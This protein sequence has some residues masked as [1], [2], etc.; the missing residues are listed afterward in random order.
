ME[1]EVR[2]VDA[3][4]FESQAD[5]FQRII[6]GTDAGYFR[7][8]LDGRFE[9]VN[10]AWLRMY[11]F[12]SREEV[13][14]LDF[15]AVQVPADREKAQSV[16]EAL[17]RGESV[18]AGEFSRLRRDGTVGYHN[19]SASPVVTGGRIVGIEGFLVDTSAIRAAEQQRRETEQQYRSLFNSMHEGVAVHKILTR[20]GIPWNY[21]VLDVNHR[22]EE[23]LGI[24]R[25]AVVGKLATDAYGTTEPPYLSEY[26]STVQTKRPCHFDTYFAPMDRYFIISVAPMGGDLFATI[27]FDITEQ[28]R[29]ELTLRQSQEQFQSI[30]DTIPGVV[31]QFFAR[32]NGEWGLHYLS[33]RVLDIVGISPSPLEDAFER[34]IAEVHPE[35][36]ERC[37]ASIRESVQSGTKWECEGRFVKPG[38]EE[39]YFRG[40]SDAHRR[41]HETVYSGILLDATKRRQAEE[42]LEKA[43]RSLA[44]AE[45]YQRLLFNSVSDAILVF[46]FE[47]DGLS[48]RVIEANDN[49]CSLFG[50][51]RQELLQ[52]RVRDL[53]PPEDHPNAQETVRQLSTQRRSI[54]QRALVAKNGRRIP[55]EVNSRLFDMDG[56]PTLI[57]SIRDFTE[58]NQA[59]AAHRRLEDQFRQAQK[60]ESIGRLAGGVAHDFNNLLTVINGYGG[61]LTSELPPSHPLWEYADEIRKAGDRGAGLTRQLLA[62]SRKQVSEPRVLDLNTVIGD[63]RR[64]LQRLIGEDI[65]FAIRLD[66]E[67]G[68]VMAD[69]E[70]VHQVLMNLVV[71]AR[72]AMPDGGRLEV[73]T[74]NVHVSGDDASIHPDAG[75]GSYVMMAVTDNGT[76]MDEVTRQQIFEPFFTTKERDKGTGL[77]LATVYGI[78]R[79]SGGWIEVLSEP[80]RGSSFK[81]HFPRLNGTPTSADAVPGGTEAVPAGETILLVEDQGGV[82]RLT[83]AM[84]KRL[85]YRVI[86]AAN[87]EEALTAERTHPGEIHLLLTDVVL[88]GKNGKE[89]ADRI[90][91]LRPGVKVLFTSGYTADVIAHRGVLDRGVTYIPKPFT[92]AQLAVKIREVLG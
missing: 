20:D 17:L 69:P 2:P 91:T 27:F 60:L 81:V 70:Q 63:S 42:A 80:S 32:D 1:P 21:A 45:R 41:E 44:A 26:A 22:Y 24:D 48:S 4:G 9:D 15:S 29:T 56:S 57:S 54:R 71:N 65:A 92:Q 52:L 34:M 37:L 62:F 11:G 31:F 36:R 40:F 38:G 30:A 83:I 43:N 77:G 50:Y 5:R 14:G 59:E 8:G 51:S 67:L 84:L 58:R 76:G 88:P 46:Q 66:P 86:A 7:I 64:M 74:A 3:G 68:Q 61:F 85:G 87:S 28:K 55:V 49:A 82:R 23:I 90:M 79:Q 16:A 35:D 53:D 25:S 73:E 72:D 33:D 89:L 47:P 19:F 75:Q 13:I 18:R 10:P 6:E 39:R 78:V 12:A